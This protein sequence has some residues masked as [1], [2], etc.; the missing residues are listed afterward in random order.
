VPAIR[1]CAHYAWRVSSPS[2]KL[3]LELKL[4]ELDTHVE[5]NSPAS[6]RF[7]RFSSKWI[8]EIT[9]ESRLPVK[10]SVWSI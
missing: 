5:S 3:A 8:T 6:V 7:A 9:S 10:Y 2:R 4:G 1:N